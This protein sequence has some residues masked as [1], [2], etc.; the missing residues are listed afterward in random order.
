MTEFHCTM[1]YFQNQSDDK[2][3]LKFLANVC[4]VRLFRTV[5]DK[6]FEVYQAVMQMA[7]F[8]GTLFH[9]TDLDTANQD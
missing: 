7:S 1:A 8:L 5:F 4:R 9:K 3:S 6:I 2:Y